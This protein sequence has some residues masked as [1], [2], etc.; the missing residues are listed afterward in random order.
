M[1]K[2]ENSSDT[3]RGSSP[4]SRGAAGAYL[5]GEIGALYLLSLLSGNRAPGLPSARV[6]SVRF[7][8][9]DHGF[10]LDD[11]IIKG[12]GA[13]GDVL[14][15]IQSKRDIQFSPKDAVYKDVALQIASS[16]IGDVPAERHLFGIATQRTSRKIS[17]AY[18]DV[19]GWAGVD[20]A[21]VFGELAQVECSKVVEHGH[22]LHFG[23]VGRVA[24][25]RNEFRLVSLESGEKAGI[26]RCIFPS[27]ARAGT[28]AFTSDNT[29]PNPRLPHCPEWGIGE[30][31]TKGVCQM[32]EGKAGR[33]RK[34]S[35]AQV[36][37]AI[38]QIAN[39][40]ADA[41][42]KW[43]IAARDVAAVL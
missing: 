23:K 12:V 8:G 20:P 17:G 41:T 7:Q 3:E 21:E 4:A 36:R 9:V 34:Y 40:R 42:G 31:K 13:S 43:V 28:K 38:E 29:R 26:Y 27:L 24:E 19:L 15:E 10:K 1:A 30:G 16:R 2:A 25:S 5:E 11:L 32:S 35:V 14:L 6:S 18:Q 39:A 33:R 22:L 37:A